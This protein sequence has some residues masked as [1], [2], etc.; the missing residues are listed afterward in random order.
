MTI[1]P[2][3]T[4]ADAGRRIRVRLDFTDNNATAE[5]RTSDAWPA[6]PD[7]AIE[8][9]V[10]D[11][12]GA[13]SIAGTAVI[14][15]V[16]TAGPG[17]V[18]DADGID[19]ST[20]RYTWLRCDARGEN[21][22]TVIGRQAAYRLSAAD[23]GS[24]IRVRLDFTDGLGTPESRTSAAWPAAT[25]PVIAAPAP[26]ATGRPRIYGTATAGETIAAGR[27]D[28]ADADGVDEATATYTWLR[29]DA[30]GDHC[31]T[32]IGAGPTHV[33]TA[34]EAG[35]RIRVR[36]DFTDRL[37]T[38]ES[39]TSAAW[40]ASAENAVGADAAN[41]AATG[42]PA[43][44]GTAAVGVTVTA[45]PGDVGDGDGMDADTFRYVW[46]RCDAQ[47]DRC[48][49]YLGT[50]TTY[51]LGAAELG[52]R[53]RVR[54]EFRD[55]DGTAESRESAPWPAWPA[56]VIAAPAANATGAPSV[57]GV[58]TAGETVT[59]AP[60]DVADAEGVDAG[61]SS[62]SWLRCNAAGAQCT[63]HIGTGPTHVLTA[64]EAGARIRV[65]LDFRDGLGTAESRTSAAWPAHPA[66]AIAPGTGNTAAR[67]RPSISGTETVG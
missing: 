2:D 30:D 31:P 9:A 38:A 17:D 51:T 27:G 52:S 58:A 26:N 50:G 59:A 63:T 15:E 41:R 6:S 66:G 40:P 10:P 67:G 18:V 7:P 22:E 36:L 24:R 53:I 48:D 19:A 34:A 21:C 65:R 20:L 28:V 39:R 16:L 45:G 43:I 5:A 12:T 35:V 37:G 33:L 13:P 29:C 3:L 11:A 47:A 46:M 55:D 8:L 54:L 61:T 64:N 32:L 1:H 56:P 23:A 44:S 4:L 62:Y 14:G 60:G 57:S 42:R 49:T 25:D